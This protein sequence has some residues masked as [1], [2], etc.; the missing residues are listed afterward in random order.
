MECKRRLK[1]E[2][3]RSKSKRLLTMSSWP[4][5]LGLEGPLEKDPSISPDL[6][7]R[8]NLVGFAPLLLWRLHKDRQVGLKLMKEWFKGGAPF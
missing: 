4:L 6:S 2:S 3:L 1:D 5:L 7:T 8:D